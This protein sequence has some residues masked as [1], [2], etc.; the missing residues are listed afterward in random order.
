MKLCDFRFGCSV[1][2]SHLLEVLHS[3]EVESLRL[4]AL[5]VDVTQLRASHLLLLLPLLQLQITQHP[6]WRHSVQL[7][8]CKLKV[9]AY[10]LQVLL[11]S[12][13]DLLH[14]LQQLLLRRVWRHRSESRKWRHQTRKERRHKEKEQ[15]TGNKRTQGRRKMSTFRSDK[16]G[17]VGPW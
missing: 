7:H 10:F 13:H 16:V 4:D 8:F 11:H 17:D 2:M 1:Y 15:D 9:H 12:F 5:R 14:L 6:S 3:F